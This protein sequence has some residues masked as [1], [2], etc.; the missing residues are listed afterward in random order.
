MNQAN[1]RPS[2]TA[3]TDKLGRPVIRTQL[4]LC[5][6]AAVVG[7]L[8]PITTEQ[9]ATDGG[10]VILVLVISALV[11]RITGRSTARQTRLR[12]ETREPR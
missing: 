3:A 6:T 10:L 7:A 2:T 4:L 12:A 8:F 11:L 5:L 9:L 1:G